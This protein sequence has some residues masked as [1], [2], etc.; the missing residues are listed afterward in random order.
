V[1]R[2]T[3]VADRRG[4]DRRS[5]PKVGGEAGPPVARVDVTRLRV[6]W[7]EATCGVGRGNRV[8]RGAG[9]GNGA[10]CGAKEGRGRGGTS[11]HPTSRSGGGAE[12]SN[13]V[14]G[15]MGSRNENV[16]RY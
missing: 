13:Q 7:V 6:A 15:L 16:V 14:P 4:W 12:L 2:A 8:V 11:S 9:G 1:D 10:A 5:E 3:H